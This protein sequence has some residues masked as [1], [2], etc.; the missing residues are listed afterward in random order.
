MRTSLNNIKE[1]EQY[2]L[3][4]S[5]TEEK[6]VFEARLVLDDD[7]RQEVDAQKTAYHLIRQYGRDALRQEIQRIQVRLFTESQFIAFRKKIENI[8]GRI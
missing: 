8:F 3:G 1:I 6:L 7:L 5:S 4:E 2:I